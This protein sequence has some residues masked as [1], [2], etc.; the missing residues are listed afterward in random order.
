ML[1]RGPGGSKKS[2]FYLSALFQS[3]SVRLELETSFLMTDLA[4]CIYYKRYNITRLNFK[5]KNFDFPKNQ[6]KTALRNKQY[7]KALY[8][9]KTLKQPK[10]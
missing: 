1:L 6:K 3:D 5:K 2:L 9:F 4:N 8:W 10:Y 7:R